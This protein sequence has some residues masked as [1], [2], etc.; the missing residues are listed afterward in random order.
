MSM[1]HVE[2][3]SEGGYPVTAT[4]NDD[5]TWA[6]DG[7][8]ALEIYLNAFFHGG[9]DHPG[10]PVPGAGVLDAAAHA[11]KGK[12]VPHHLPEPEEPGVTY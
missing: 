8:P 10:D 6:V 4:L 9:K 2:F 12:V 3:T 5:G 7:Y 1:G 11:F